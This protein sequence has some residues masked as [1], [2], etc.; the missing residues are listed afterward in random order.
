MKLTLTTTSSRTCIFSQTSFRVSALRKIVRELPAIVFIQKGE[1]SKKNYSK[2]SLPHK[3]IKRKEILK[4]LL[5]FHIR[6]LRIV[7]R[8]YKHQHSTVMLGQS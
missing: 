4:M 3:Q 2:V 7:T 1:T 6:Y 8:M 5:S